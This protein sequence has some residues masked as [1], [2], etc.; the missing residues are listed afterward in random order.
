MVTRMV[1]RGWERWRGARDEHRRCYLLLFKLCMM[2]MIVNEVWGRKKQ[3]K[4]KKEPG[5]ED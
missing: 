5:S 3:K 1:H 2:I 4:K